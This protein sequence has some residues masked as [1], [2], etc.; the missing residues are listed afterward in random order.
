MKF[1]SLVFSVGFIII[2]FVATLV[3]KTDAQALVQQKEKLI[4]EKERLQKN[5]RIL[6]LEYAYL[7]RYERLVEFS[8]KFEYQPIIPAKMEFIHL[9][10]SK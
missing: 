9:E 2:I 6:K 3:V 4:E 8:S 10:A 5:I 7:S 1:S